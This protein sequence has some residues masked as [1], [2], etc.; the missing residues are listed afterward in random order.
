MKKKEKL[1]E[2]LQKEWKEESEKHCWEGRWNRKGKGKCKNERRIRISF[3]EEE[4]KKE[5]KIKRVITKIRMKEIRIR[6]E[7]L[8]NKERRWKRSK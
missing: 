7:L 5:G 1:K 6:R 3:N 2:E 4:D 8:K